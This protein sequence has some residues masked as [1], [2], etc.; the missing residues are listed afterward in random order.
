MII[1]LSIKTYSH[2]V[3]F[4]KLDI[5]KKSMD[6]QNI[7]IFIFIISISMLTANPYSTNLYD[8][9]ITVSGGNS[10][11]SNYSN[12]SDYSNATEWWI[13]GVG[14]VDTVNTTFFER[15]GDV[16]N[17]IPSSL[18]DIYCKLTGCTMEGDIDM[19]GND[20]LNVSTIYSDDTYVGIG[21][22][23]P[24]SPLSQDGSL[25]VCGQLSVKSTIYT[26]LL[27]IDQQNAGLAVKDETFWLISDKSVGKANLLVYGDQSF[28][29]IN[30]K[31][32][33]ESAGFIEDGINYFGI[34]SPNNPYTNPLETVLMYHNGT[35]YIQNLL[36]GDYILDMEDGDMIINNSNL[37]VDGNVNVSENLNMDGNITLNNNSQIQDINSNN[38]MYYVEVD[39][40]VRLRVA[41]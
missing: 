14:A 23:S 5:L 32:T 4:N 31:G 21:S 9:P 29:T 3:T 39:G 33:L 10:S 2:I 30:L 16:L 1:L 15:I 35:A 6:K 11:F 27:L 26:N 34:H 7:F 40:D 22:C 13:T 18:E 12:Y 36:S 41:G 25:N 19:D 37:N 28:R 8:S 17:F 38:S 24:V 20:I